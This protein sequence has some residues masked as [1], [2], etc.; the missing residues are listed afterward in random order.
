MYGVRH[1]TFVSYARVP[2]VPLPQDEGGVQSHEMWWH[3]DDGDAQN[4]PS[5]Q[6]PRS[7]YAGHFLDY[8]VTPIFKI[9]SSVSTLTMNQQC[10]LHK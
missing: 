3:D 2:L 7:L 8:V 10:T 1:V 5:H 6:Q 4:V 9:V